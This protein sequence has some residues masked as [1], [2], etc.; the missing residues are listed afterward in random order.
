MDEQFPAEQIP[1]ITVEMMDELV[2]SLVAK[3]KEIEA[4]ELVVTG[5]NKEKARIE[6][7]CANYLKALGR[8]EGGYQ[9][10]NATVF[11]TRRWSVTLPQTDKDKHALFEWMKE[12]QVFDKYATVN[13]QSLNSLYMAE[14]EAAKRE[15]RGI[16]FSMPGIG[17]RTLF[18][19]LSTR[20]RNTE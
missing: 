18:E 12:K 19:S 15:G 14:W 5:L 6:Q 7:K 2:A 10:P 8:E 11:I 3:K 4:A 1:E 20:K 13:W 9:A 16:E 17:E